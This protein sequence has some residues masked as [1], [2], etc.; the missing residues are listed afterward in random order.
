[1][2]KAAPYPWE[3]ITLRS[4]WALYLVV[5]VALPL[6]AMTTVAFKE[7]APS[8]FVAI[9][10]GRAVAAVTLTLWTAL[11]AAVVNAVLGTTLA[12][13]MTRY[14]FLG[15]DLLSKVID[16]PFS[17]PTLVTGVM[18]VI[19]LGPQSPIGS[20][21]AYAGLPIAFSVPGIVIALLFVTLPIVVRAVEPVLLALDPAEEEAAAMLGAGK[22]QTFRQVIWPSIRAA[23]LTG[24]IQTFARA[25][26]EFGAIVVV[27]G[28][29]PGRTLTA[30][31]LIYGE[32]EGGRVDVAASVSTVLL[33][34]AIALLWARRVLE[35][36]VIHD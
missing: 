20:R 21:L 34:I 22:L 6:A 17:I 13:V 12:W 30:P 29:I 32:V 27:S 28:N 23:V 10:S 25:I 31:V 8:F 33:V 2:K 3:D 5:L 16:L 35:R 4:L 7:G 18:I 26:A 36:R 15:R 1:M 19:L 9:T 14:Q 11:V 24:T